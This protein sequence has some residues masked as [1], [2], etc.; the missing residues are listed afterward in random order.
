VTFQDVPA[1]GRLKVY[2]FF[3]AANGWQAGQG[4]SPWLEARGTEGATLE[5]KGVEVVT[6]EVRLGTWS[7]YDHASKIAYAAEKGGHHW[8]PA[9]GKPPTA[10][11]ATK[12]PYPNKQIQRLLSITTAQGPAMMAYAWQAT[13][14]RLPPDQAGKP[15][16][17]TA[18]YALQ[19]LSTLQH[20]E[21]GYAAP[22][23]GF[24]ATPGIVYELTS[25]SEG[26]GRNF[27]VDSSRGDFDVER[28]PQ[29]GYHLRKVDLAFQGAPPKLAI[30]TNA[31][32][33]RFPLAV[34]RYV[35]HPQGS[36]FGIQYAAHKLYL[37]ELPPGP[38]ADAEAPLA[39]MASGE[40]F[41]EGLMN[42]PR[43]IATGLDGRVLV[44]E[45]GNQRIQAFDLHGNP[46]PYFANPAAPRRGKVSTMA[47][48]GGGGARYL[49]LAVEAKGYLYVLGYRGD[50]TRAESYQVDLYEPDGSF[51]V[52]TRGFAADKLTV[53][54]LRNLFALNYEII[55]GKD[56]RPEPSV[57]LWTP[58]APPKQG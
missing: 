53:D 15:A 56:G 52:S 23:V 42:G 31:S 13:G 37:L 44:L 54:L 20:P 6:N 19:N 17:D 18:L 21:A 36:V 10:T 45:G 33:G 9:R 48:A 7:T 51:L 46:V 27:F 3:Y 26:G 24:S 5:V 22:A 58:A 4:E 25:P 39:T 29:G 12:S 41:R 34:D 47:L 40:G 16:V 30:R 49:D 50:G 38:V 14:L 11:A 35:L 1:G 43:A 32:W 8:L 57:S 55:L 28:N 2:V